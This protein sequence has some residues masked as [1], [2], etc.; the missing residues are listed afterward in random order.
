M[1]LNYDPQNAFNEELDVSTVYN[2]RTNESEIRI[3][4]IQLKGSLQ[5]GLA[6]TP[7]FMV[8]GDATKAGHSSGIPASVIFDFASYAP[9]KTF[10]SDPVLRVVAD[11]NAI[12]DGRA[13][14]RSATTEGGNE[15]LG[16]AIP[17]AQFLKMTEAKTVV[18]TL[19]AGE[20]L[21]SDGHLRALR[22]MATYA[23]AGRN[24]KSG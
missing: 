23:T 6:L 15:F 5:E 12:F 16:Q 14:N 11:G 18:V 13:R 4:L 10:K 1:P 3:R 17:L 9:E 8:H 24:R 2:P 19:G 20:Y 21:L 7:H 22:E